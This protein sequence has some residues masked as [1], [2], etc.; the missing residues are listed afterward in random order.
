ME[1]QKMSALGTLPV[2]PGQQDKHST[3]KLLL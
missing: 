3:K 1:K 2:L